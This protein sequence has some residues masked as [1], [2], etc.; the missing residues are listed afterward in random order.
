MKDFPCWLTGK[1]KAIA[2]ALIEKGFHYAGLAED[3]YTPDDNT[4]IKVC[5][6]KIGAE[7]IDCIDA[8]ADGALFCLGIEEK[9]FE[10]KF[11]ETKLTIH[12]AVEK[13]E[14]SHYRYQQLSLF[15][16]R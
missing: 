10:N 6:W 14:S 3:F 2:Q 11:R 13:W 8:V 15:E 5:G 1:D 4:M 16:M 9:E 7:Y 12:R